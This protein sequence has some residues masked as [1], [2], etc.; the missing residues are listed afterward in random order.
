MVKLG[1]LGVAGSKMDD[2]CTERLWLCLMLLS[3][4]NNQQMKEIWI[5]KCRSSY[6]TLLVEK[7]KS[8]TKATEKDE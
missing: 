5:E 8:V 7:L 6:A 4:P 3:D 1:S 2:D